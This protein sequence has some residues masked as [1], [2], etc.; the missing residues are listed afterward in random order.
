MKTKQFI[1]ISSFSLLSLSSFANDSVV[2]EYKNISSNLQEKK[3][4][5]SERSEA[6]R[7]AQL[8]AQTERIE[9]Y[10]QLIENARNGNVQPVMVNGRPKTHLDDFN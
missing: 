2:E 8:Q 3:N 10:N 1:L 7:K 4:L 6:Y 5:Q 9:A